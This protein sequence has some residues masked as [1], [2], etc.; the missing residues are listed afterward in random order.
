[1]RKPKDKRNESDTEQPTKTSPKETG[2][3]GARAGQEQTGGT[4]GEG[5]RQRGR[6]THFM[7]FGVL[8]CDHI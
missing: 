4:R 2:R 5:C 1:M 6:G 8:A 7:V 3:H